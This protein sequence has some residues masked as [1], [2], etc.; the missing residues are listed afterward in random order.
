MDNGR[1]LKAIDLCCGAGGWA[2]A[3]RGLPIEIV[4]AIDVWKEA[5]ET[6]RLNHRAVNVVQ[7]DLTNCP[8][9]WDALRR[10]DLVVG[11]I[12]CQWLSTYRRFAVSRVTHEERERER[13][14]LD[15]VLG[16]VERIQPEFWCLED[17]VGLRRELPIFTP[18]QVIDSRHYSAQRRK[19]LYV[20]RFPPP[21]RTRSAERLR[22]HLRPGPY[23]VGPRLF[24]REPRT[25]QTFSA[26]SCQAWLSDRKA[27]TVCALSSRRDGE[28]GVVDDVPGGLRQL[29]WQEA[30]AL[31]GYPDDYLFYGS[32]TSVCQMIANSVQID[33]CWA[34]L[35]AIC[36]QAFEGAASPA[37]TEAK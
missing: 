23:R 14:L 10:I 7:G 37:L 31:Q 16:I 3:A 11:G 35:Q 32:P 20:G 25:D 28:A 29:E 8:I 13:T 1:K 33:T 26:A 6:Y 15:C 19:R 9:Q 2:V 17:V 30:A 12:P 34:I 5:A 4:L 22:D 21:R 18:Y 24:G 36:E 27:P